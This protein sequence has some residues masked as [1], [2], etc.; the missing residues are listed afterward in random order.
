MT[1]G[2]HGHRALGWPMQTRALQRFVAD[3]FERIGRIREPARRHSNRHHHSPAEFEKA[4]E[5]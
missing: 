1:P 4:R 3:I 5:A 2:M